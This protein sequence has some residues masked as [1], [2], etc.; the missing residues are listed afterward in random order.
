MIEP[1]TIVTSIEVCARCVQYIREKIKD[2]RAA[3]NEV[4]ERIT[5]VENCWTR[6]RIQVDFLQPLTPIIDPEHH[7][8]LESVLWILATKLSS[9]VTSLEGVLEK[10]NKNGVELRLGFLGFARGVRKGKYAFVKAT[11]DTVIRDLEEWQQRFDPSW[12]LIMHI[13]NPLIDEQLRWGMMQSQASLQPRPG[14]AQIALA[15][16][17]HQT[18]SPLSLADGIRTAL[19]TE[20]PQQPIFLPSAHFEYRPIPYTNT[21]AA[22]RGDCWYIVESRPCKPGMQEAMTD[23]IRNLAQ[24]LSR[25]DPL[26]FGLLNCKGVMRVTDPRQ[27]SRTL[28]FNLI[29]RIPNGMGIPQSLRQTLILYPGRSGAGLSVTRRVRIARELAKSVSYVHTFKFVHKNINPES[30]LLLE[31]LE[32]SHSA[33]FLVGFDHFRSAGGAT[34]LQGDGAWYRDIYRHPTRQ[35]EYPEDSY[36]MQHDIYSLG[37]CLLEVGLWESFVDYPSDRPSPGGPIGDFAA[38]V[39]RPGGTASDRN[40]D[41]G[42]MIF[43]AKEDMEQLAKERLPQ[44]MGEKYS[45]VVLS[46]LTCLDEDNEDFGGDVTRQAAVDPDGILLGVQFNELILGRLNEIVV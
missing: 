30:V 15:T 32:S 7:R 19:R 16:G 33:T 27:P 20:S 28:S 8:V 37:V 34:S 13:E 11:L 41:T 26:A 2:Y 35:G 6:T 17:L 12:F 3:D 29:F 10:K 43:E 46:C 24:K 25:A 42:R 40:I 44:A 9:A 14:R 18:A 36:R 4:E 45:Q 5:L 23:D 31:D 39:M 1:G 38:R 21:K 22:S